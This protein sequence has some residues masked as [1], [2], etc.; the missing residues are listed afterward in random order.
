[1]VLLVDPADGLVAVMGSQEQ[2]LEHRVRGVDL[3]QGIEV[4]A[5]V[6]R[7]PALILSTF[8]C[9]IARPVSPGR[10]CVSKVG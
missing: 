7:D 6:R 2:R 5:V 10:P 4:A 3:D 8:S 9:D 1:L